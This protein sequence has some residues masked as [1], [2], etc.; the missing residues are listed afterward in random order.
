MHLVQMPGSHGS[1]SPPCN[2]TILETSKKNPNHLSTCT[3]SSSPWAKRP[4]HVPCAHRG[5]RSV[6][7]MRK[8]LSDLWLIL[9]KV[10][11]RM[12]GTVWMTGQM[13]DGDGE[14]GRKREGNGW[15]DGW[16]DGRTDGRTDGR[17]WDCTST[18]SMN[19]CLSDIGQLILLLFPVPRSIIMCLFL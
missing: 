12:I 8:R 5:R 4:D 15:M 9:R 7:R 19:S 14:R 11:P 10:L 6:A 13:C 16:M 1:L 17:I 2:Y 18:M 3:L